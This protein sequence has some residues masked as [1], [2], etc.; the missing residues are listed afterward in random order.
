MFLDPGMVCHDEGEASIHTGVTDEVSVLHT[1]GANQFTLSICHLVQDQCT[2]MKSV[3]T[4]GFHK[5][6]NVSPL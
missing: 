5:L 1:V 4:E 3:V 6:K 2:Q